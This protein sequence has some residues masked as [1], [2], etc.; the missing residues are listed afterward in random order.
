[1]RARRLGVENAPVDVAAATNLADIL[2]TLDV[3][4]GPDLVVIDSI[5][6]IY[7]DALDSAP[8]RWR[9]YAHRRAGTDPAGEK[10]WLVL[11]IVGMSRKRGRS[12]GA[13]ARAYGRYRV[14]LR[15]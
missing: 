13:R 6:T 8:G 10:T 4:D 15:R 14:V 7:I 11:L 9:R 2:A 1:M 3:P 5:Q 12:P